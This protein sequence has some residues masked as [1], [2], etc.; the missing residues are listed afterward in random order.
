M[1]IYSHPC[2]FLYFKKFDKHRINR[3]TNQKKLICYHRHTTR[4]RSWRFRAVSG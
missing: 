1:W 4:Q 2:A 3:K